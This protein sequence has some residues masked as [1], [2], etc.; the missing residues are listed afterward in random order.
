M[1]GSYEYVTVSSC[2]IAGVLSGQ[3]G[4][5]VVGPLLGAAVRVGQRGGRHLPV[6]RNVPGPWL[7]WLSSSGVRPCWLSESSRMASHAACAALN[8]ETRASPSS[9]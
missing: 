8:S 5:V 6:A 7:Q 1:S 4:R 9:C 2:V 3:R